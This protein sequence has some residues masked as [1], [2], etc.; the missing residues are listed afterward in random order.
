[1]AGRGQFGWVGMCLGI[2]RVFIHVGLGG[3]LN[4]PEGL[5]S[6]RNNNEVCVVGGEVGAGRGRVLINQPGA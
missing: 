5:G 6:Q 3:S 2:M 1:M 4:T